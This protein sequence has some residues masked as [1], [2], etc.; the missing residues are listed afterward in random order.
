MAG[1]RLKRWWSHSKSELNGDGAIH[2]PELPRHPRSSRP[3]SELNG[4]VAISPA[5]LPKKRWSSR[6]KS[7]ING[8]VAVPPA[9]LPKHRIRGEKV[10]AEEIRELCELVRKRFSLD[11]EIWNLRYAKERDRNKVKEKIDKA[12]AALA[13]IRRILAS[14]DRRDLFE[15]VEDWEVLQDIKGRIDLDGKRDWMTNPPWSGE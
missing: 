3:G 6:P 7:E 11:V 10:K 8:T 4:N 13:K 12:D 1:K 15:S 9:D 14:W 2:P 5:D